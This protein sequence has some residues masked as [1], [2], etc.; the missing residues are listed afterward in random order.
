MAV[1]TWNMR[2]PYPNAAWI[3]P[4]STCVDRGVRV[5][6]RDRTG[7]C[8]SP[9]R[10]A[11]VRRGGRPRRRVAA[12]RVHRSLNRAGMVDTC[13]LRIVSRRRWKSPPSGSDTSLA[14][15]HDAT[16]A[17]PFV[18]QQSECGSQ[19]FR[20]AG[21]LDHERYP[22]GQSVGFRARRPAPP[23]RPHSMP[24]PPAAPRRHGCGVGR[25]HSSAGALE[26]QCGQRAN[27]AEAEQD[28]RFAEQRSGIEAD[29]QRGLD[30]REHRRRAAGRRTRGGRRRPPRRRTDPGADGTRRRASLRPA[31]ARLCS[32]IPTQL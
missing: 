27:G 31:S 7:T 3:N 28:D 32:T 14:P 30:E 17:T 18:R 10:R 11:G 22:V 16:S 24:S 4:S 13:V 12:C 19:R 15:Y 5:A 2:Y 23:A 1:P 9:A 21:H 8:G 6:P 29:L 26:Q 25:D 20:V